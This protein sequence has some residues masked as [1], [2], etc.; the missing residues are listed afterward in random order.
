[1]PKDGEWK[2]DE[3][4]FVWLDGDWKC[5]SEIEEYFKK[6]KEPIPIQYKYWESDWTKGPVGQEVLSTPELIPKSESE[7]EVEEEVAEEEEPCPSPP[8]PVKKKRGR[9]K[10]TK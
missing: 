2:P 7:E 5:Q 6:R 9:P 4:G 1:M 3:W 10:K 8:K